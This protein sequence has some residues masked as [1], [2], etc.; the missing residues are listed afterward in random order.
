MF[1][2]VVADAFEFTP[3]LCTLNDCQNCL[4]VA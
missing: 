2:S 1:K 3:F 4:E